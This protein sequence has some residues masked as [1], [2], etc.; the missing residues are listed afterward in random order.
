MKKSAVKI[1]K[2]DQVTS[3]RPQVTS[4]ATRSVSDVTRLMIQPTGMR[5]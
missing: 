5:L 2:V 4:S 3:S 1:L